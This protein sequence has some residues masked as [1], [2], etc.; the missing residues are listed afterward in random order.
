MNTLKNHLEHREKS[1]L[2]TIITHMLRQEPDLQWLLAT[3]LPTASSQKASIDLE[4]YQQR[5]LAA[6]SAGDY[7]R[8]RKRDEVQRRLTAIKTIAD[9]FAAQENYAAALTIYEMLVTEV[10]E[11]F[12]DYRDEYVAFSVLLMGCIDGSGITAALCS[13]SA[14]TPTYG[15]RGCEH[16]AALLLTWNM[17]PEAFTEMDDI[18]TILERQSKDQLITLIKQLLQKQHE[19]EWQ[20]TMPPLPGHKS[21]PVDTDEYRRLVDAAFR[22]AGREWDA[23]YGISSDLYEI[24]AAAGL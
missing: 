5:V 13:C 19:V 17:Q 9:E 18:N 23:V 20:L 22:H 21:V 1:E 2:I 12:N 8:K 14:G 3:P 6:M 16:A 11:H 10:I 4:L 7:Q 15:T 24:T